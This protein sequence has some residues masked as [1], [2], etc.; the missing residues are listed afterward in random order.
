MIWWSTYGLLLFGLIGSIDTNKS[1]KVDVEEEEKKSFLII[2][3]WIKALI[4]DNDD[5]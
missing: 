2:F 4:N 3:L 1:F 5:G